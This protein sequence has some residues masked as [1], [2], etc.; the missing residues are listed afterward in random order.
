M[1]V[2]PI[3]VNDS[4]PEALKWTMPINYVGLRSP[5]PRGLLRFHGT[6]AI[7]ILGSGDQTSFELVLTFPTGFVYLP[8]FMAIEFISDDLTNDFNDNG[9]FNYGTLVD[10]EFNFISP[11][12]FIAAGVSARRTWVPGPGTPKIFVPGSGVIEF[13][14]A[15]MS[16]DASTAGDM[17]YDSVFYIFDLDQ[18]DKFELNTPIPTID[19]GAF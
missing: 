9:T 8:K 15:D 13:K 5:I 10:T 3:A 16:A 18:V 2:I 1:A 4:T 7:P 14:L 6:K 11:G 19:H 12:E 17:G